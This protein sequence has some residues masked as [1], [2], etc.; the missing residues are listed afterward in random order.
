MLIL[1]I[2]PTLVNFQRYDQVHRSAYISPTGRPEN[3]SSHPAIFAWSHS[4]D[5]GSL[6]QVFYMIIFKRTTSPTLPAFH[7]SSVGL[8]DLMVTPQGAHCFRKSY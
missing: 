3:E 1:D 2:L 6:P 5:A 7:R 4:R 8:L